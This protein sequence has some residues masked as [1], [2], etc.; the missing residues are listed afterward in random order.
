MEEK[1]RNIGDYAQSSALSRVRGLIGDSETDRIASLSVLL[2]GLGGVGS[3]AFEALVRSGVGRITVV[4]SDD[5][6]VSNLNRQLYATRETLGQ[7]KVE[8]A[9]RRAVEINPECVVTPIKEFITRENAENIVR[10]SQPDVILDAIDNVTAKLRMAELAFERKI[11]MV[12]CLGTGNRLD[13]S[14]LKICD[15]AQTFGCPLAR[16]MRRE[17]KKRGIYSMEVVFSDETPVEVETRTPA[18]MVFVPAAAGMLLAS[19]ILSFDK[20]KQSQKQ[21]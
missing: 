12:S 9:A 20:Q 14:K 21:Q 11:R 1:L 5:Y 7:P 10:I 16:I 15:I 3:Y 2:L 19:S 6:E 17:L 8:V 13:V 4:D 18:S